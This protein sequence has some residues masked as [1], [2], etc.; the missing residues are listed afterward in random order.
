[1]TT[2]IDGTKIAQDI[3]SRVA[4]EVASRVAAGAGVP[5]LATIIVSD[6]P[7]DIVV[8]ATGVAGSLPYRAA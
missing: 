1:M 8:V 2:E 7:A 5:G 6:D 3:R 4:Q